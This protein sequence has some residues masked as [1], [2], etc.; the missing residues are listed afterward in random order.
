[1]FVG[2]L[3]ECPTVTTA[4]VTGAE[5]DRV[6]GK[7]PLPVPLAFEAE[8]PLLYWTLQHW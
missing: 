4:G 1:M 6:E 8:E 2:F 7:V 5:V 3:P